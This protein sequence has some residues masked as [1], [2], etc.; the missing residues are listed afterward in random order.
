MAQRIWAALHASIRPHFLCGARPTRHPFVDVLLP[1]RHVVKR[2][3]PK[4]RERIYRESKPAIAL[5]EAP[6]PRPRI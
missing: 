4:D 1:S 6:T 3:S 2:M 5:R